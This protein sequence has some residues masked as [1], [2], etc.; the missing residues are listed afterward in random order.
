M[1]VTSF[2]KSVFR[3]G[4]HSNASREQIT[5]ESKMH[6]AFKTSKEKHAE[7]RFAEVDKELMGTDLDNV[8]LE[9][10]WDLA[11]YLNRKR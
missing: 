9:D 11:N 2:F 1:K 6:L 10:K 4:A 3:I 5:K 7:A 8:Q